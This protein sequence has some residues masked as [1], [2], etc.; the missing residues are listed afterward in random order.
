MLI[1]NASVPLD[2]RVWAEAVALRDHGFQVSIIGPRGPSI[3]RE[4]YIC[5]RGIHIYRYSLPTSGNSAIAYLLEYGITLL[6][7]FVLSF[8]VWFRHGFDVIHAANPPDLFFLIGLFFRPFGK[9]FIYDQHDLSPE[10]FQVKFKGKADFFRR[11]LL[12]FEWCSYRAAHVVLTPNHAVKRFAIERGR[13]PADRIFVVYNA[14]DPNRI[15][16]VPP[17]PELKRGRPYLLVYVGAIEVQDGVEYTLYAFHDLVHKR[18]RRD[19]SLVLIGDGGYTPELRRLSHELQLDEYVHFTGWLAAE[20]LTRYLSVADVGLTPEPLNGLNEYC[21]MTKTMEYMAL[22]KPVVGFDLAETRLSAQDAVLYATPNC[23]E[24]FAD[25]IE[26]LLD[27]EAL[28]IKVGAIGRKR[29]AEELSWEHAKMN[30]V[31]AYKELA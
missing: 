5:L 24:D 1:E 16:M 21:T 25:K 30:L 4:M 6:M 11:L 31:R 8:K 2:N 23:A 29:I 12:F 22:G 14:P 10:V 15:K 20:E 7:T 28:R 9:K 27:D 26:A 18:G 17:E 3:D 13:F 19:V